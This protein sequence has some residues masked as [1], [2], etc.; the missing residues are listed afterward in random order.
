LDASQAYEVLQLKRN[1]SFNEIKYAY[2]KLA[3]E[4]HPDK[5]NFEK[6]GTKFKLVTEAYHVLKHNNKITNSKFREHTSDKYTE[7]KT[8]KEK[9]FSRTNWGARPDDGPPQEDWARYTKQTEQ[10]DPFFWKSYVAEF[11]K[12]YEAKNNQTKNPYDFEITEEVKKE[13]DLAVDVDHS[14]CIGCCSCE[15]IAPRVFSVDKIT[16]MNPKSNVINRKGAK[17]DKIMDAAQ[18]C[19]TKA[20][21]VE[22]KE[23]GRRLY[24][25]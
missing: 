1:S 10:S 24:P 19:P 2:R 9:T 15:T 17:M 14:R 3:L 4:L 12:N 5:N 8:K 13:P 20:I 11:W 6:D 22:E 21:N 16:K 7:T 18:T 23:T 25:Y